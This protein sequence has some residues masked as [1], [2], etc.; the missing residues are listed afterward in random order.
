MK[1]WMLFVLMALMMLSAGCST[2]NADS[3]IMPTSGQSP[4]SDGSSAPVADYI[5]R[6]DFYYTTIMDIATNIDDYL[7]KRVQ[8]EGYVIITDDFEGVDFGVARNYVCCDV[9]SGPVGMDCRWAAQG[10]MPKNDDWVIVSGILSKTEDADYTY[11]LILVD[12][13]EVLPAEKWG[14]LTVYQ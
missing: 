14:N 6:E 3:A 8:I 11:P 5:V 2:Q 1:K 4:E 13:V 9:D 10:S 7:G 12:Y